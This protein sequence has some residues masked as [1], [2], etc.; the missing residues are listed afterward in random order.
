MPKPANRPGRLGLAG[1][2]I[3]A[4]TGTPAV[5][6]AVDQNVAAHVQHFVECWGYMWND[7]A[8]HI[9]YCSPPNQ[10]P[11]FEPANSEPARRFLS[12]SPSAW[13]DSAPSSSD[14]SLSSS[15]SSEPPSESSEPPNESSSEPPCEG[16]GCEPI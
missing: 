9:K 12:V 16:T 1:L 15:E 13:S 6:M 4:L 5:A 2:A 8:S 7:E 14:S 10:L 3:I 11:Y